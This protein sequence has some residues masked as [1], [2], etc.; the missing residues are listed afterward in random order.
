MRPAAKISAFSVGAA[1]ENSPFASSSRKPATS[2]EKLPKRPARAMRAG[3]D[4]AAQRLAVDVA[5]VLEAE[6]LRREAAVR[7]PRAA[8]RRQASRSAVR[9]ST[10]F[11]PGEGRKIDERAVASH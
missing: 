2:A 3:A 9:A 7:L 1:I 10:L 5:H 6:A 8:L 11:K 4:D